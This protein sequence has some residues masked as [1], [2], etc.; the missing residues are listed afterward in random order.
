M[1]FKEENSINQIEKRL[2]G[3]VSKRT[4]WAN[5]FNRLK[6]QV[7]WKDNQYDTVPGYDKVCECKTFEQGDFVANAPNDIRF[8]LKEIRRL[9]KGEGK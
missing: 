9:R 3:A 2:K 4:T 7:V 1:S 6:V 8:L 5:P